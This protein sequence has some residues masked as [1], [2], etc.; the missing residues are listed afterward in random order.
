[1]FFMLAA[2]AYSDARAK[3]H[4]AED[5]STLETGDSSDEVQRS[6]ERR[7]KKSACTDI[8]DNGYS[9]ITSEFQS[10]LPDLHLETL[11]TPMAFSN[12]LPEVPRGL[13]SSGIISTPQTTGDKIASRTSGK[14]SPSTLSG[15][16]F[17]TRLL[18][19]KLFTY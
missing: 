9:I 16:I 3:L 12:T 19:F 17:M 2:D 13:T 11:A 4:L 14:S 8:I 5:T 18:R 1:M 7:R 10:T 6:R 15:Y